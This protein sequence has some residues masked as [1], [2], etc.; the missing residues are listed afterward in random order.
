MKKITF[1]LI[2]CLFSAKIFSQIDT[3]YYD[4]DWKGVEHPIFAKYYRVLFT[5]SNV[6]YAN[7]FKDYWMTGE[8]HSEGEFIS[9]DKFDDKNSVFNGKCK[10]YYQNGRL[11]FEQTFVNGLKNGVSVMYYENGNKQ[12]E[13]LWLKDTLNGKQIDYYENGNKKIELVVKQGVPNGKYIAYYEAGTIAVSCNYEDG[14]ITGLYEEFYPN[15][16]LAYSIPYLNDMQNG[17][18]K[19]YDEEGNLVRSVTMV[20]DVANGKAVDMYPNGNYVEYM[21]ENDS[22]NYSKVDLF[23]S[24]GKFIISYNVENNW[25][26]IGAVI[27]T[28]ADL[29]TATIND[30]VTEKGDK[31]AYYELNG[32]LVGVVISSGFYD[33]VSNEIKSYL[34][35]VYIENLGLV[36]VNCFFSDVK[37]EFIKKDKSTRVAVISPQSIY[38]RAARQMQR[39]LNIAYSNARTTAS[40]A[41]TVSSSGSSKGYSSSSAFGSTYG[42]SGTVAGTVNNYGGAAVGAAYSRG[43]VYGYTSQYGSQSSNYSERT[44]DGLLRYQILQEEPGKVDEQKKQHEKRLNDFADALYYNFTLNPDE[45]SQYK[46]L[47]TYF[48]KADLLRLT[49]TINNIPY[50]FE[51]N[52]SHIK[53]K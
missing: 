23:D 11:Q 10:M 53:S 49:L 33:K 34:L 32:L 38:D 44:V 17:L 35:E 15:G 29:K 41:A 43:S 45:G 14:K 42:R 8:L 48:K 36:P 28:N 24:D 21:F 40:N 47:Y 26:Q 51:W 30:D 2:L 22:I 16:K 1:I 4:D 6:N 39:T 18:A 50:V 27:P 12:L 37:I 46:L 7:K 13:Y 19:I 31:I 5:S 9:I 20:N 25:K 3:V 52:V